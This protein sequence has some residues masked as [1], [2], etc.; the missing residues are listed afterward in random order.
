MG[1]KK[2]IEYP[3]A[4]YHVYARGNRKQ[5]I[6]KVDEDR[7]RFLKKLGEYKEHHGFVLFAYILMDNHFH[8]LLETG[9]RGLSRTM[10]VLLQSHS[11]FY[12]RK[13][14]FVGHLFQA[15]YKAILCDKKAY[16]LA[17]VRYLHLN[18][19]RAGMVKDPASYAWSSHR[20]YLG[21]ESGDLIDTD[22]VLSQFSKNRKKAIRLYRDFMMEWRNDRDPVASY[23]YGGHRILGEDDFI[24][25][26][27]KKIGKECQRD[28]SQIKDKTLQDVAK[29]VELL[30]G[31]SKADLQSYKRGAHLNRARSLFIRLCSLHVSAKRRDIAGFLKRK[32][33]SLAQMERYISQEE[34]IRLRGGI[35]W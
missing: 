15:R 5:P 1:R 23:K 17:L 24:E 31:I 26:V 6:F 7:K 28:I 19:V 21:L 20:A 10:Q 29:A 2:R 18:C 30:M 9:L 33:G 25:E 27:V 4:F 11:L 32:P 22:F 13:Y 8:L 14:G 12:N 35:G 16:L 3:G 34:F